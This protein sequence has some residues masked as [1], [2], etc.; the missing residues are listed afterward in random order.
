MLAN[1]RL[2]HCL[3]SWD[4]YA[5]KCFTIFLTNSQ[6]TFII[7]SEN[8]IENMG[9]CLIPFVIYI[10]PLF[11]LLLFTITFTSAL[12]YKV[13]KTGLMTFDGIYHEVLSN[14]TNSCCLIILRCNMWISFHKSPLSKALNYLFRKGTSFIMYVRLVR[15]LMGT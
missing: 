1:A 14:R 4:W 8:V 7:Y 3:L 13:I 2:W 12:F 6:W 5:R 9:I 15:I 10:Q 11:L